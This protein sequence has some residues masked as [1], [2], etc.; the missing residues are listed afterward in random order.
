MVFP[1]RQTCSGV[2]GALQIADGDGYVDPNINSCD[3]CGVN[4]VRECFLEAASDAVALLSRPEVALKWEEPSVLAEFSVGA[5]AGHLLRGIA[6][7]EIYLESAMPSGEFIDA[8]HYYHSFD[9]TPDLSSSLN[10]DVRERGREMA[11]GGSV[12]VA[13]EAHSVMERLAVRL[14]NEP[15]QR[16][17]EVR[18]GR[19]I[20]LDEYL[21]TR[22]VEVVVHADDLALSV[23]FRDGVH[24]ASSTAGVAIEVLVELA[25]LRH[26][27]I[28]VLRALTRRERDTVNALRV[29]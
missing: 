22:V 27:D 12:A 19:A 3:D 8:A 14:E 18:G 1:S 17:V 15:S 2:V 29:L 21:R 6:T 11:K 13:E 28:A 10:R 16:C 24:L 7:V 23:G 25:R 26:G 4:V 5:L 20:Y 9:V